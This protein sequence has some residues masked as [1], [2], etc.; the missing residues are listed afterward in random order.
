MKTKQ[1]KHRAEHTHFALFRDTLDE[2][3]L[4]ELCEQLVKCVSDSEK[5]ERAAAAAGKG[6]KLVLQADPL[7]N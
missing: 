4:S 6:Q 5:D 1:K 2:K 3:R 7:A